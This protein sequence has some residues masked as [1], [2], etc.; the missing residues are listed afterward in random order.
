MRWTQKKRGHSQDVILGGFS[1]EQETVDNS[2]FS[3][4]VNWAGRM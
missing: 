1:L 2:S 4:H 3:H